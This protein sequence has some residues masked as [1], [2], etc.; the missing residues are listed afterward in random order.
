MKIKSDY[1]FKE[2]NTI[3]KLHPILI[4]SFNCSF[5]ILYSLSKNSDFIE[6]ILRNKIK[7]KHENKSFILFPLVMECDI[8]YWLFLWHIKSAIWFL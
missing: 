8:G 2:W 1:I 4:F 6:K 3:K 7:K 5:Q